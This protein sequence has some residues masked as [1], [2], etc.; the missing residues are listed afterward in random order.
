MKTSR[1]NVLAVSIASILGG[2]PLLPVTSH[3]AGESLALE[4]IIVTAQK[5]EENLQNV[6]ISV[7]AFTQD[8]M[9]G[10]GFNQATDISAQTPGLSVAQAGAG[11]VNAFS[12]R[13][14]TQSDFAGVHEGPVAVYVD[15]AYISQNIVT[16]FSMYDLARVEV[17]RGPQ[18]TLF[19]R[20]ATGGLVNFVTARPSQ[21]FDAYAEVMYGSKNRLRVEGAVGGGLTDTVSARLSAVSNTSDG[22]IKNRIGKDGQA[23]NDYSVRGQLLVEPSDVLSILLKGQYSKDDSDRGNYFH[24]VGY[25]GEFL[26]P[27]DTDFFG[28]RSVDES[29]PWTGAWDYPGFNKTEI[30]QFTARMDWEM[31]DRLT[32]TYVGDYQDIDGNYGE[33]S[34]V[35]P[36]NVFNYTQTSKVKQWSQEVRLAWQ[37]DRANVVGGLYY[38]NIDGDYSED[39]LVFGQED[40]DWSEAFYG[41]PEPGGYNLVGSSPQTTETWAAFGQMDYD[42]TDQMKL[43]A[44]ARWTDD[45]KDYHFKQ[46]WTNVDG[47]WVF[48]EGVEGPG[49]IPYF[50]FKDNYSN[51][52]W[53]GKVQLDYRP[54][55][56]LL[57]Y[58]SIN[59]GI[60]AGGFNAPVD[61]SGLIGLNEFGQYIPF[62][63]NND[64][65]QY[66]SE[67]LTSYEA[68]FKST[69]FDGRARFNASAFYYDYADNQIFNMFGLTQVVFNSDGEM[70]GGELEFAAS[71]LD[72]L[73]LM[74]GAS[75]LDATVDL[76]PGIRPDG[77]TTSDPVVSPKTTLNGLVR[78]EWSIGGD[79]SLAVQGDFLWKDKQIFNL[80]NT[81]VVKEDS[82]AV[83]NASI[84]FSSGDTGLYAMAF[85]KNLFDEDYRVG[86]FDTTVSF[87]SVEGMAGPERWYGVT[88]GYRWH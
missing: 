28:Y 43:T 81:P 49:D 57:W 68:G 18:G 46:G 83:V 23:A 47:L 12:I 53:S 21:D 31:L 39:A 55:D 41:I 84:S 87:G 75:L 70:W 67:V 66:D 51:G 50:D 35:S 15:E 65:M 4:E 54:N 86:A 32:L 76:P 58:G 30:T 78:Y 8:Q 42:I 61:A 73:D 19:G 7:T 45:K 85:V 20:N 38:L 33:D 6:G 27:P 64:A 24:R 36:A 82:Y 17:L 52:D 2:G 9:R 14:V 37:G 62:D 29:D 72:G 74:L 88:L 63:Q 48:F 34:D 3:A 11:V 60:K 16:N 79:R 5:R 80:S 44:G 10:F 69:L 77:K 71:P 13:G 59:R 56:D 25:N 26:P 22:L 1:R 40:F